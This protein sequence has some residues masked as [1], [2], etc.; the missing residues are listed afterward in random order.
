MP[1]NERCVEND[2][3]KNRKSEAIKDD[4][5]MKSV[6]E[7]LEVVPLQNKLLKES[8]IFL[9]KGIQKAIKRAAENPN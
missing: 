4:N 8:W 2:E 9:S 3:Q 1:V 5:G 7:L 6:V